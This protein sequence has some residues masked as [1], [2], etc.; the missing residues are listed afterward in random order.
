MLKLSSA[1]SSSLGCGS[2]KC[3]T[4][5][6]H[7]LIAVKCAGEESRCPQLHCWVAQPGVHPT[8]APHFGGLWH[9]F[10]LYDVRA[11]ELPGLP[12]HSYH[13]HVLRLSGLPTTL[14]RPKSTENVVGAHT[15]L[16]VPAVRSPSD[17]I[18][19]T[20]MDLAHPAGSQPGISTA[21]L[22]Y[23]GTTCKAH[24]ATELVACMRWSQRGMPKLG[25]KHWNRPT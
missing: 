21:S 20:C 24:G 16:L 11:A 1:A 25:A 10:C 17:S 9:V 23:F 7:I 14:P 5:K 13:S 3:L 18:T 15:T 2:F 19:N 12:G 8:A 4:A 6:K 22:Q